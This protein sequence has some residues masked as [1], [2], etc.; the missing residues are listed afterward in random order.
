MVFGRSRMRAIYLFGTFALAFDSLWSAA[1]AQPVQQSRLSARLGLP[2][3]FQAALDEPLQL[4]YQARQR[5]EHVRDYECRFI[6]R[7][8]IDGKLQPRQFIWLK[9]RQKPFSVYM[10]WI[11]VHPGRELIYVAGRNNGKM[12]VHERGLKKVIAGTMALDP[13][14]KRAMSESRHSITEVGIGSLIDKLIQN[15]E[16]QRKLGQTGVVVLNN[17]KVDGR[18][19][20][21]VKTTNPPDPKHYMFYRTR[22][23]FDKKHGLPIRVEGYGWPRGGAPGGALKEEYTYTD[24]KLNVGLRAVAFDPGNP[25]YAFGRF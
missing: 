8:S 17:T 11:N 13:R 1:P 10:H 2:K 6:K 19:C 3:A 5:F 9:A 4:A 22:I 12:L 25:R 24:L 7:E 14:G 18:P 21:C 16:A 23:F 15:W 20:W